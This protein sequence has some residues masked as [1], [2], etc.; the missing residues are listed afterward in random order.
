[1]LLLL[2]SKKIGHLQGSVEGPFSDLCKTMAKIYNVPKKENSLGNVNTLKLARDRISGINCLILPK[3]S[4]I[5]LGK[6]SQK[7]GKLSPFCG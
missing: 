2:M 4:E 6:D 1:M 5:C 3:N 7:N